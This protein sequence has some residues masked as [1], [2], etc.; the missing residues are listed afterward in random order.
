VFNADVLL[1]SM[2]GISSYSLVFFARNVSGFHI[3]AA[4]A[5][6]VTTYS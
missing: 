3:K 6:A 5:S 4:T 2:S 1:Q